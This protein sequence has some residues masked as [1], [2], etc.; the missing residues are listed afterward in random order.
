MDSRRR[1]LGKMASVSLVGGLAGCSGRGVRLDS[2][3]YTGLEIPGGRAHALSQAGGHFFEME[4]TVNIQKPESGFEDSGPV[5]ILVISEENYRDLDSPPNSGDIEDISR[6][7]VDGEVEESGLLEAGIYQFIVNNTA[8][9][10]SIEADISIDLYE[11]DRDMEI[12]EC[13][14]ESSGLDIQ[15]LS[16]YNDEGIL[17]EEVVV[18]YD[19]AINDT[20]GYTYSLSMDLMTD[21]D[22]TNISE[23]QERDICSTNFVGVK[24]LDDL[25]V[26]DGWF[27]RDEE[28]IARITIEEDGQEYAQEEV[29]FTANSGY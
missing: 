8:G 3:E 10:R 19:I 15:T 25:D 26:N 5:D 9:D 4:Y 1:F 16:V 2:S 23:T 28:M 11:Y 17:T 13:D 7:D 27:E 20:S 12:D 29:S 18:R 22:E 6:L 14:N 24:Q 21:R